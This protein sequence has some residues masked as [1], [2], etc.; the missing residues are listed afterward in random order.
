MT[1][2]EMLKYLML[3]I[4]YHLILTIAKITF[5]VLGD[6]PTYGINGSFGLSE[7]KFKII[8]FKVNTKFCLSF[9][10]HSD[11]SYLFFNGKEIFQFK[12]GNKK[13]NFPTQF[14][15][16]IISNRFSNIQSRE[17]SLMGNVYDFSVDCNSID[18][19]DILKIQKYLMANNKF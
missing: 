8:F 17:V 13:I 9:H 14:C 4:L 19:S 3:I 7:K 2:I 10:Y 5:L 12:A 16:G 15:L 18:K 11:N 1:L 6:G